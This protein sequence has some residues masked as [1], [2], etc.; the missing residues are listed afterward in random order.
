MD[1]SIRVVGRALVQ[2][3]VTMAFIWVLLFASA[4]TIDWPR[5]WWFFAAFTAAIVVSVAVL[6]RLKRFLRPAHA[7]SRVPSCG[8]TSSSRW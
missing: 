2:L 5:A 3:V 1:T 8:T 6:Y 7:C 4:G